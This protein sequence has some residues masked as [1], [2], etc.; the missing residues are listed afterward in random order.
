MR[1]GA[2][3]AGTDVR[4]VSGSLDVDVAGVAIDSRRVT[5]GDVF[6]ALNG[7]QTD[8][9]RF[10]ADAIARGARAIVTRAAH[11][12]VDAPNATVL[13]ATN[14][15]AVLA[16]VAARLAGDPSAHM[17]LVG[18]TGTNGK[19][20][21]TH[22]LEGIWRAAGF[23]PGVIGTIAYRFAGESRP[24]PLT[25]PEA[26]D[27]QR[28]LAE[29]R[30]AGVTH[31]VM[32]ASSIAIVEERTT[33]LHF[34]AAVFTNLTLD[35]LDLHG[36]METYY[37]AK[38]RLFTEL[39]PASGKPDPVA[40]VNVD[41][42]QGMR[43][44]GAIRTRCVPFGRKPDAV[45][46]L[47]DVESTLQGTRG[48]LA[49]GTSRLAFSSPLVGAP[50][51]GTSPPLRR[52]RGDGCRPEHRREHRGDVRASRPRRADRRARL[53]RH[54]RLRPH[55]R[56]SSACWTRPSARVRRRSRSSAAAAT[57]TA[58]SAP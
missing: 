52:S 42:P 26:P 5:P 9:R 15:R 17:T 45:V 58:R 51:S 1:L 34:D 33:A 48:V 18:V 25:T 6:F 7:R 47:V 39:L 56:R 11:D 49:L 27:V 37:A 31:A 50:H 28:L 12:A 43:L 38:A 29:M 19:T 16:A 57:A 23:S 46:R 13:T 55:A 10:V 21:T 40:V 36:D 32:E 41:D 3:V 24:A 54:R 44:A 20:T 8:G 2:L 30:A 53:H 4:P 35:H 22:L 14:P